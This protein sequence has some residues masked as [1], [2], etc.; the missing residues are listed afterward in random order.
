MPARDLGGSFKLNNPDDGTA[1]TEMFRLVD[2]LLIRGPTKGLACQVRLRDTLPGRP[3]RTV[4]MN[5]VKQ[6]QIRTARQMTIILC[7]PLKDTAGT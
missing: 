7:Y 3:I 6:G 1:I 5:R 4:R 2:G